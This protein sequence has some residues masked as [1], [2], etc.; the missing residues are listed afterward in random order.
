MLSLS[1]FQNN[2]NSNNIFIP[3][4]F[5]YKTFTAL[6]NKKKSRGFQPP[7]IYNHMG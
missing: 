2:N 5:Y 1:S 7:Q 6:Y 3:Y 4:R